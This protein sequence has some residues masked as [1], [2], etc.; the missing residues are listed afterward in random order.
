MI[1]DGMR[2]L[3]GV[4]NGRDCWKQLWSTL[5]PV[6]REIIR[7]RKYSSPKPRVKPYELKNPLCHV[8]NL[9]E[10]FNLSWSGASVQSETHLGVGDA[11][12]RILCGHFRFD[13]T[14][15]VWT[16]VLPEMVLPIK[17]WN[18]D[19]RVNLFE[20][21][22]NGNKILKIRGDDIREGDVKMW[23]R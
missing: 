7:R 21:L 11:V 4:K 10:V 13:A 6:Q 16:G 18:G 17:A 9:P 23:W 15:D 5:G 22:L 12:V 20:P 14:C 8:Q 19:V 1:P 3:G 2:P